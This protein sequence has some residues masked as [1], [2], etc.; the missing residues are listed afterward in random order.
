MKEY[1]ELSGPFLL[2]CYGI[3]LSYFHFGDEMTAIRSY[4]HSILAHLGTE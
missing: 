4:I 1:M 2:L 3:A